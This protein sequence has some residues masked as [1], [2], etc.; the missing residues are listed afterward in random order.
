MRL[1]YAGQ[2]LYWKG[3]GLGLRAVAGAREAGHDVRLTMVGSGREEAGWRNL[4]YELGISESI[5]W[6]GWVNHDDMSRVYREHDAFIFPSLHDSSGN[7]VLEALSQGLPVI[8]LGLG[9][10]AE[11]ANNECGRVVDV[12]GKGEGDC[13]AGL[14]RAIAEL[15]ISPETIARLSAGAL[16]RAEDFLW[17]TVVANFYAEVEEQLAATRIAAP[18]RDLLPRWQASRR[19]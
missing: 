4:A 16:K 1:L 3:M 15:A 2:F 19:G 9:G 8:C 7:V 14:A 6:V 5:E 18:V 17:P 11:I 12:S 13:I 10:P